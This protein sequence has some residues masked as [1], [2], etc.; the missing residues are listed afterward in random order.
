MWQGNQDASKADE[1]IC[2]YP[3]PLA[4]IRRKEYPALQTTTYLDHAGTTPPPQSAVD[5]FADEM[6]AHLFGNPHS[7]SPASILSTER[8]DSVRRQVLEFFHADPEH[9]DLVFVGNA[10]AAVKL[11]VECVADY[12]WAQQTNEGNGRG[13]WYGYHRDCHTSLVGPRELASFSRYF[14]DD[15]DVEHWL[16]S[17]RMES[18]A[19]VGIFAYPAQSNMNGRRLP[20]DW[21]GRLR[22]ASQHGRQNIYS[23]LDAAAYVSTAQLD[24]SDPRV[25]P[26][27]ISLSFYKIFGFPDI[28]GLIVRK[29]A[30]HILTWRR[31][32]GGGTVDMVVNDRDSAR[33]WHAR[34]Q[35]ALHEILEDGTPPFLSVIALGAALQTHKTLYG[36]MENVSK[37]TN[38]LIKILYGNMAALTYAND[39]KVCMIYTDSSSTRYDDSTKQGP[40]IAFNVKAYDGSWIGKTHF[41]RAAIVAKIQLRTG[42]VCNPGGIAAALDL[43]SVEMKENF[44]EGVRCGNTVDEVQG[45]PTGIVRVSLGAMTDLND[46]KTFFTFLKLFAEREERQDAKLT[47]LKGLNRTIE[48]A[49]RDVTLPTP[50][51]QVLTDPTIVAS[52]EKMSEKPI[53]IRKDS[54]NNGASWKSICC[55]SRRPSAVLSTRTRHPT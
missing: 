23:L 41:E 52:N 42:G 47:T 25:A 53:L 24:L 14:G 50:M 15:S 21:P 8:M 29:E 28:G 3:I 36:S 32:L 2:P 34:K 5:A 35:F 17:P 16:A 27:F 46:V 19:S 18:D 13:F 9:F 39:Q 31:Y 22:Q 43:S 51:E 54:G 40:T 44:A 26:D 7:A 38:D 12:A 4:E 33:T 45:K 55:V 30:G 49:D 48:I 11:V 20:M 37:H 6:K 10:T 1:P